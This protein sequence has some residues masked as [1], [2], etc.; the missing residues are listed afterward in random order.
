MNATNT[1]TNYW[2]EQIK[3]ESKN[4]K[5]HSEKLLNRAEKLM[6]LRNYSPRTVSN[7][8][9]QIK[10][11]LLYLN[12]DPSEND[13]SSIEDFL[14]RKKTILAA[15]TV[16][17][18]RAAISFLYR[19]ILDLP[20]VIDPIPFMRR[21]KQ[22]P[23]VY[24]IQEVEKILKALPFEQHRTILMTA[25]ACGLRL[26]E[27]V[28]LKRED[29]DFERGLIWVRHG[30]GAKD[31]AIM[32]DIRLA[33]NIK[34]LFNTTTPNKHVFISSYSK[35][36]YSRR[37]VEKIFENA[38]AKS[39]V[40]QKGGIHT[41]RHSFATHLLEQGTDLRFIQTLLGHSSSTTTEI[42][43]HVSNRHLSKI[44]SPLININL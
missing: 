18:F 40:P 23:K 4:A 22:L 15:P 10:E 29:I 6:H 25:Y 3:T 39:G 8:R 31:R 24:S 35:K 30:K 14:L 36:P 20:K 9:A 38:C 17:L 1:A 11:Y 2:L 44:H 41:L 21:T 34:K 19:D 13:T 5:E 27:I 12:R 43:T 16:N 42:Y 33:E 26:S 28:D 37:T 32:L 7:Y